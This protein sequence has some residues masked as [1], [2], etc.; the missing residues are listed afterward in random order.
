LKAFIIRASL[1][2]AQSPV[3]TYHV[4]VAET[5]DDAVRYVQEELA[6]FDDSV[7]LLDELPSDEAKSA[8]LD[9]TVQGYRRRWTLANRGER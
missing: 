7:S 4:S 6:L 1:S 9:L 5:A 3:V 8:H 2:G